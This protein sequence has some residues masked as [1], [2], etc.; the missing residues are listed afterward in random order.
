[1][2]SCV[3]NSVCKVGFLFAV[4]THGPLECWIWGAINTY[5]I[6]F[7][8]DFGVKSGGAGCVFLRITHGCIRYYPIC[9]K[10]SFKR[11]CWCIQ[12]ASTSANPYQW[13][14]RKMFSC[15]KFQHDRST[16]GVPACKCKAVLLGKSLQLFLGI[17][18][19]G[20]V[21]FGKKVTNFDK[22]KYPHLIYINLGAKKCMLWVPFYGRSR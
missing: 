2:T 9:T 17:L 15:E 5:E 19:I 8:Q 4:D 13:E 11:P 18:K 16:C 7:F 21:V 10:P 20:P 6:H 1:M 22:L 12:Q 14:P 3:K